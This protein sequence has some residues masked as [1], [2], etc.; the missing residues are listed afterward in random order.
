VMN[1]RFRPATL[2]GVPVKYRKNVAVRLNTD[3]TP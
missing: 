1:W 2:K 3:Q